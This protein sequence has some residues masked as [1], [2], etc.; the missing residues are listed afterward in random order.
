MKKTSRFFAL[1]LALLFL[2]AGCTA[3]TS[4]SSQ[5]PSDQSEEETRIPAA[6]SLEEIPGFSGAPFVVLKNNQPDFTPNEITDD[7]FEFYSEMDA[8]G[9]CGVCIASIGRDL[10]PTE[11]RG[12][13][14]Q[15]KPSGWQTVKYDIVD[16][17]YLYNRCHLIGFQLT[18]E[19]A[20]TKNL[21]TGTRYLNVEGM[22]PFENMVADYIKETGNHVM[23][24]V[25]PVFQGNDLLA[26]GVI[27]EGFSVEDEGE[28]ICFHVFCY[29]VQPQITINYATGESALSTEATESTTPETNPAETGESF[30]LNVNSKKIH[31]PGCPSV[32]AISPKNRKDYVGSPE[33]L[34]SL[35]Y[36]TCQSCFQN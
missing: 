36:S 22:L 17:K 8:W 15:V 28:G 4:P 32:S 35:G 10:M 27:M 14:G 29:N 6:D 11:D 16:G 18:G 31:R 20:N 1:F 30:V 21:I 34:L 25:T 3:P 7:S 23:Y 2:L 13:I 19:N 5:P 24:R 9:R 12:S 33:D 26:R